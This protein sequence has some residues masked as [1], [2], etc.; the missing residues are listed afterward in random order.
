MDRLASA[1]VIQ[2]E[3]VNTAKALSRAEERNY[4]FPGVVG[5]ADT[6]REEAEL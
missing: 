1:A 6:A 2:R 3:E 5:I 4:C